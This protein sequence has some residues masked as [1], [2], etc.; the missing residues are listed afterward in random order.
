MSKTTKSEKAEAIARLREIVPP[1]TTIRCVLRHVSRSGMMRRIDFYAPGADA[2][3][4]VSMNFLTGLIS[5]ACGYPFPRDGSGLKVTGCGM[6]MGF[7]VVYDLAATLYPDGFKCL[8]ACNRGNRRGCPS[9]DHSNG[10]SYRRGRMHNGHQG[11]Y[12]LRCEWL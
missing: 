9:A 5:K 3:G 12:A 1:G 2:D 11:G 6:D 7:A 4:S 10:M 8:G